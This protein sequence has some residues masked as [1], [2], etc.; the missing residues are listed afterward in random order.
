MEGLVLQPKQE[1]ALLS[2]A[3]EILYG[4]AAGG[5]KSYLLRLA[6]ILYA[7]WIRGLIVY[8]FRRTFKELVSNHSYSPTAYP[9]MLKRWVVKTKAR[10]A[11]ST[12]RYEFENGS[13]I[14]LSHCQ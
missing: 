9:Q 7:S 13:S 10:S 8:L 2:P 1:Q 12:Y 11:E 4:G 14:Q 5:G 3:N 6:S